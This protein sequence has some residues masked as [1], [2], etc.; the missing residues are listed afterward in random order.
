MAS[1]DYYDWVNSGRHWSDAKPI[2]DLQESLQALGYTV[3]TIGNQDHLTK[4]TPE[5]HTP[6][7]HTG[8]PNSAP[9]GI[10]TALDIMPKNGMADLTRL[11]R[12][13]IAAKERGDSHAACFKYMN[14]TNELGKVEHTSWEPNEKTTS[15]SDSGHIH[16]SIRTDYVNS[17]CCAG[18]N[19]L[20]GT[21]SPAKPTPPSLH[22]APGPALAF[23]L[24]RGYYFGPKSGPDSS[25]S[26][27]Y[28]RTF[29]GHTDRFWL[30]Q[31]TGQL[32]KRGWSIGIGKSYLHGDGNN[33]IYGPEYKALIE[34]FQ[35][36][37]H[38]NVDGELGINTW[39]AAYRNPVS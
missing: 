22:P 39:N 32:V 35:R 15:S 13:L 34:A 8:W 19:P 12:T 10:V 37:Q 30:E 16:L 4:A 9:K 28:N 7:S 11:A 2:A 17:N 29:N 6:F 31:W 3:Y 38:L 24:P 25:V 23:P 20:A 5:D 18:W 21:T 26:G 1:Q 27:A 36:D 14:W 33:G